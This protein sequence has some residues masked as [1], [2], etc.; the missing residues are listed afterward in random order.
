MSDFCDWCQHSEAWHQEV[1]CD[2]RLC[3]CQRFR[4]KW[5][6]GPMSPPTI[7]F[8]KRKDQST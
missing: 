6:P 2:V 5:W 8:I 7:T 1:G 3:Q 4:P